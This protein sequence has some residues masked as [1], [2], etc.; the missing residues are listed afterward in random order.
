VDVDEYSRMVDVGVGRRLGMVDTSY[1]DSP[2]S[3]ENSKRQDK[4]EAAEHWNTTS[5][6]TLP[7]LVKLVTITH[8]QNKYQ[9]WQMLI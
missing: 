1:D 2:G 8:Q 7:P 9:T 6:S 3:S 5:A 4:A